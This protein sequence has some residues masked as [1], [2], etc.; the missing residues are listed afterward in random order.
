[1]TQQ[2]EDPSNTAITILRE[3]FGHADFR[4]K[5]AAVVN[6]IMQGRDAVVLFPTGA[7][8]SIC[9]QV[10]ALARKGTGIVISPL[11]ALMRDQVEALCQAGVAAEALNS[12][13]E[14]Q[15]SAEV[16]DRFIRGELDLLYVAPERFS[17]PGFRSMLERVEASLFAI[18]EAHCISQWGHDFRPEYRDI[19]QIMRNFPSVPRVAL[20]ATADPVTKADIIHQL[21]MEDASVFTTSFDRPNI[22]Y[23]ID[24]RINPKRQLKEFLSRHRGES[25]IVY[26]LSRA[27]VEAT[28]KWLVEEG[29]RAL[30]YH[31]GLPQEE[32][33]TNQDAFLKQE[34][35]C[36]VATVAFGMGV[37]KPDVRYVAHLDLPS[38]VEAYYQET[39]RAGRD[40]QPSDAWMIYGMP[41]VVQRSRM[42]DQGNAP[43]EIKRIERSKL[44]ALL[45]IC[46]T[47]RCRRQALLS[48]FG[49]KHA[50]KCGNCDTCRSPVS[51]WDGSEAAIKALAAIYR[52]DQMFGVGH[53]VDVLT[54]K[55]TEKVRYHGHDRRP[56]FGAGK[57]IDAAEWYSIYRQLIV[58]GYVHVDHEAHGALK[59]TANARNV[60]SHKETVHLRRDRGEVSSTAKQ[61]QVKKALEEGLLDE[62]DRYLYD[63]LRRERTRIAKSKD[64]PP[65]MVLTDTTLRAMAKQ[66]PLDKASM[67]GIPGMGAAKIE[68]YGDIF[69]SFVRKAVL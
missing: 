63:Y 45:A 11:I 49:E 5:Q 28:A 54:G 64:L 6:H 2:V 33:A 19:V 41:D 22:S 68:R 51:S 47:T 14:P 46:E 65:Y 58:A 37:D 55:D 31:A 17:T 12:S 52:T 67:K 18:D 8:K 21:E 38:S 36:L 35:L 4:G 25:G 30:P 59:L 53:L 40:G 26:C 16:R 1:M 32:R 60:F 29:I 69:A 50:G 42:I 9:Y 62:K 23:T 56:V 20:T 34:G 27:K 10:P 39:G 61:A 15:Q 44:S 24:E 13:M 57:E 66:K 3:V 7:G 48:H 43:E